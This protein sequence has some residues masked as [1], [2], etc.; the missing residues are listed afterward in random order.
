MKNEITSRAALGAPKTAIIVLLGFI[1]GLLLITGLHLLPAHAGPGPRGM[2]PEKRLAHLSDRLQ[3]DD[4]QVEQVRP[5]LEDSAARRQEIRARYR[6]QGQSGMAATREEMQ[7][8]RQ[9]T[10][11]RLGEVLTAE[12]MGTFRALRAEQRQRMRQGKQP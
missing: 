3:L 12:Q 1:V 11:T 5:I 2:D 10:E 7:T 9:E 6:S 8:L 4:H